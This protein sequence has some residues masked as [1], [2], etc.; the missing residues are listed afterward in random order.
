MSADGPVDLSNCDR[1]PIHQLGAI[2]PFGFLLAVTPEWTVARASEN[3]IEFLGVAADDVIG[4]PFQS[5][6]SADAFETLRRSVAHLSDADATE[7]VFGLALLSPSGRRFDCALHLSNGVVVVEAEPS[8]DD[9]PIEGSGLIR[10]IMGRLDD[11]KD[12]AGF[13]NE[14]ARAIRAVTGFDRVM[15]YRF[16]RDGSGEVVAEAAGPGIGSFLNL[17]FP[18]SDIPQQARRLYVRVPF[19]IIADVNAKPVAIVPERDRSGE[20]IDLSLSILRSVSPIHIEYLRNMGVSAS[21]SISI[22]VDG[23]LWGLFACH[24]DTP[25]RPAFDR[26]SLAELIGQMFGMKLEARERRT[27][28]DYDRASRKAADRLLATIAGDATLLRKPQWVFE[29]VRG[30]IPCDGVA[31]LVDGALARWGLT[32]PDQGLQDILRRLKTFAAGGVFAIDRIVDI[33]P[34]AESYAADAAGLLAI[35]ISRQPRDYVVLFRREK[36][37]TSCGEAIRAKAANPAPTT[38]A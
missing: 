16:D 34:D 7:R 26:R 28:A 1:E 23:K 8:G 10:S 5:L 3:V 12:L 18:A 24:H 2:Q 17:R 21:L 32:P 35:P 25:R 11:A 4:A 37:R 19:R 6:I 14:G 22:V 29:A 38:H 13:L 31:V 9:A 33:C 30:P 36:V 20:P 15:V 27:L